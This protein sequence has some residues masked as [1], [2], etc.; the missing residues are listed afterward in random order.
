MGWFDEQGFGQVV[1]PGEPVPGMPGFVYGPDGQPVP[2]ADAAPAG[3][4]PPSRAVPRQSTG[5]RQPGQ[6][7]PGMPGYVYAPDGITVIAEGTTPPAASGASAVAYGTS[8][9]LDPAYLT[10]RITAAFQQSRGRGPTAEELQYWIGKATNPEMYSDGLVRVGWNPYWEAR[11]AGGDSDSADVRLAGNEGVLD[12]NTY[13]NLYA[14]QAAAGQQGTGVGNFDLTTLQPPP[15]YTAP[16]RPGYLQGEFTL[17]EFAMPSYEDL[18]NSPGYQARMDAVLK[19]NERKAAAQGSILSGG[20]G[21]RLGKELQNFASNEYDNLFAQ[22][23]NAYTGGTLSPRLA[24]RGINE[25]AYQ[26]DVTNALN[27]YGRRYGA[28]RDRI[29]DQFNLAELGLRGTLGGRP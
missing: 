10:E 2:I 22:R 3:G 15:D 20:Y 16:E 21:V 5:T 19:G 11:I 4:A 27:Q 7:V 1:N 24:A 23:M 18:Q 17:P 28:V 12:R 26:D 8:A 25:N 14:E 9:N 6:P 29:G 13:A